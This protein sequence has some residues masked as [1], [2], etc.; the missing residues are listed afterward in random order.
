MDRESQPLRDDLEA[1]ERLIEHDPSSLLIAERGAGLIGTV[2]A[3]WDGWRGN[4]YRLAV[5]FEE[6]AA[7]WASH[8]FARARLICARAAPPSHGARRR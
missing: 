8:S 3:A 5:A 4:M 1:L 2:V 7:A 6:V